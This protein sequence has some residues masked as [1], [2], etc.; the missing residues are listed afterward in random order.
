MLG[1]PMYYHSLENR[2]YLWP[3]T[4]GQR[5]IQAPGAHWSI[6]EWHAYCSLLEKN[7][8]SFPPPHSLRPKG[9]SNLN[10]EGGKSLSPGYKKKKSKPPDLKEMAAGLWLPLLR[11]GLE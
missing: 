8:Y 4:E 2:S 5:E 10:P 6:L 7:I 1:I 3:L 9:S 11:F